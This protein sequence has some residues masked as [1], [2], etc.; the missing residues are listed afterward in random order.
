VAQ[1]RFLAGLDLGGGGVRCLLLDPDTGEVSVAA[2]PCPFG[3]LPDL[4]SSS[5]IDPEFAWAQLGRACREALRLAGAEPQQVV[6]VAASSMRHG[7]VLLGPDGRALM[8]TTNRD[9]RGQA[10]IAPI[11]LEYGEE[12]QQRTGRWPNPVSAGARLLWVLQNGGPLASPANTHLSLSDWLGW[13]LCGV[14][15]T[16][17]SQAGETLLLELKTRAW[18][19]DLIERLGFPRRWFPKVEASGTRLGTLSEA[20][21]RDLGFPAGI[22]VAQGGGDTQCA[23]LAAGCVEPGQLGIIAGTSVPLQ[24]VTAEPPPNP[25]G[26][27]WAGHHVVQGRWVLESNSGTSGDGIAWLAGL[28]HPE[29]DHPE[30][31]FFAEAESSPAGACGIF[32]TFGALVMNAR[33]LQ[34]PLGSLTLTWL[35]AG[36]DPGRRRHLERAVIEGIVFAQ[37]VN[38]E[39]IVE[40]TGLRPASVRVTGGLSRS[41]LYTQLVAD[42]LE[43]PVEVTSVPEATALAAALCAGVGAGVFSDLREAAERSVAVARRH[44]PDPARAAFYRDL[45]PVWNELRVSRQAVDAAATGY[46]L[47]GL[48]AAMGGARPRASTSFR[49]RIL[50]TANLDAESLEAL[51]HVGEVEDASY[52]KRKRFLKGDA[53]TLALAGFHVFVTEVDVVE[54]SVLAAARDLRLLAVCRGDAVNVDVEAATALGIPVLHTP[55]RNADAVADL[56]LAFLLM[57]GR[58][59][60]PAAAYLREPGEAGDPGRMGRAYGQLRGREL[61]RKTLGLVGLGAVGRKVVQRARA[62][63]ARCLVYDPFLEPDQVRLAGAEP[64]GLDELLRAS[65]FVSLHANVSDGSRGLIGARELALMRPT[66]CLVNTA[67][68]ALVDEAALAEALREGRLAGA[69]LDVFSVEPP[70]S[71]HPLV[72]LPNVISTP[73]VGGNTEDVPAH[74]GAIVAEELARLARGEAP[75]FAL[76]RATLEGFDWSKPRPEPDPELVKRLGRGPAPAITDLQRDSSSPR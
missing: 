51:S 65:D 19:E 27:L 42:V 36:N 13:K 74:Q 32:S 61:W 39:Q 38:F 44:E 2:L 63:G 12:I 54:A 29:V 43:L 75:R 41:R 3:P 56:T 6:G 73:H 58:K 18:A 21:A 34:M 50:V 71:D 9:A 24:Q 47:R 60:I 62:C 5:E 33:E 40:A 23:L 11:A 26:R 46:W 67:R 28:L 7:S 20:A 10:P 64:A 52:R 59:L 8:A 70:G 4:P 25:A 55:G 57:L 30:L 76:N 16:D 14:A 66:A 69:A 48:V 49:P 22:P 72:Q 31:H 15:A 1:R 45:Q 53:L 37:R 17:P 68:A 35:T